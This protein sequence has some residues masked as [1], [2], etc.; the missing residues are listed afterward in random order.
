[1][2][3]KTC[4][5]SINMWVWCVNII[6]D[7]VLILLYNY[8]C[9]RQP[10]ISMLSHCQC[11]GNAKTTLKF[12]TSVLI[13]QI[14]TTQIRSYV[15]WKSNLSVDSPCGLICDGCCACMRQTSVY[16]KLDAY[17]PMYTPLTDSVPINFEI[18][19]IHNN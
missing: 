11:F 19:I 12:K 1:M 7:R 5:F 14:Q 3:Y 6:H 15:T 8:T 9:W 4:G 17:P 10:L 2:N 16:S 13:C 18:C